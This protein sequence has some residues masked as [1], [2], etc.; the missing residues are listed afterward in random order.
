MHPY[1]FN[2][3]LGR[4]PISLSSYSLCALV[5]I[6]LSGL[7][8]CLC[9]P[10]IRTKPAAH[11]IFLGTVMTTGFIGARAAQFAIDLILSRGSGASVLEVLEGAG[12][13]VTGGIAASTV[14]VVFFAAI[15]PLGVVTWRSLDSLA[16]AFP[17]GHMAGRIGCLLAGCC[18]GKVSTSFPIVVT[19]PK[20][21]IIASRS[22][23][24]IP[25]GPRI[26]SPLLEAA[27]LLL[28]GLFLFLL[29]KTARTRGQA[30]G[31][32][33]LLYG[34]VR[35]SVEF[36]RDDPGRG[37]WGPLSTGQWF[38]IL[39]VAFGGALLARYLVAFRRDRAGPP[40]LPLNGS[41]PVAR[42]AF[43]PEVRPS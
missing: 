28:I 21:W 6:G 18:Y 27:G 24:P 9:E 40:F 16:A 42:D 11:I 31:L 13:T 4:I 38:S 23:E 33:F 36:T 2:F 19:Y 3:T 5:G 25:F 29:L 17:F 10:E 32:Y 20:D 14:A 34:A 22:S 26:A 1:I 15:D 7:V 35:F 8:Y 37:I 30:I 43:Q 39:A 12:A 41:R